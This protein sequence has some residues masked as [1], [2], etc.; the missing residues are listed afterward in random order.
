MWTFVY[1]LDQYESMMVI[2]TYHTSINTLLALSILFLG[3]FS[4]YF[5]AFC[6]IGFKKR[7]LPS[8]PISLI[9]FSNL[10]A[11]SGNG[12]LCYNKNKLFFSY[13]LL[14]FVMLC[15]REYLWM[16][17]GR[18]FQLLYIFIYWIKIQFYWNK[19]LYFYVGSVSFF[20]LFICVCFFI[21]VL[22]Y[23]FRG[24]MVNVSGL[25]C[26]VDESLRN[27]VTFNRSHKIKCDLHPDGKALKSSSRAVLLP[28]YYTCT[29]SPKYC[30]IFF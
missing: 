20:Q 11:G 13:C 22:F 18:Y 26:N 19:C 10:A 28:G 5:L 4:I 3:F 24:N 14:H 7:L 16:A 21:Y 2:I 6:W 30:K 25:Q 17:G 27:E 15:G 23:L 1:S 12:W 8:L 29:W 9:W